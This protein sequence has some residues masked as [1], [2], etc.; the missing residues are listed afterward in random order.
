M[1]WPYRRCRD[2]H[3]VVQLFLCGEGLRRF[4]TVIAHRNAA[5]HVR[6][7]FFAARGALAEKVTVEF[8]Q[9]ADFNRYKT[10]SIATDQLNSKNPARNATW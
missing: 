5:Y 1:A 6:P 3:G 2:H 8:D 10:F 7:E 4:P 9:A